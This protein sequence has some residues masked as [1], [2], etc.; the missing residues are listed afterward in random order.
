MWT[1]QLRRNWATF[2]G[3]PGGVGVAEVVLVLQEQ[4]YF[5]AGRMGPV[6]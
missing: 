6:P 1:V 4:G 5:R 3:L 2:T